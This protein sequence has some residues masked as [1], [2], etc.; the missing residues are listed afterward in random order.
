M[1]ALGNADHHRQLSKAVDKVLFHGILTGNRGKRLN[2]R[3]IVGK[4]TDKISMLMK[5]LSIFSD[6]HFMLLS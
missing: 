3:H 4:L 6:I 2:T 5:Y 1:S